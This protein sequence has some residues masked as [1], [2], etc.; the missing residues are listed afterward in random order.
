[1]RRE[2]SGLVQTEVSPLP[3]FRSSRYAECRK[4]EGG[5]SNI[6]S[7]SRNWIRVLTSTASMM[8]FGR[9]ET[10]VAPDSAPASASDKAKDA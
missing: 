6:A 5:R 2:R 4:V 7:P 9:G 10:P 3:L 8:R 1:M